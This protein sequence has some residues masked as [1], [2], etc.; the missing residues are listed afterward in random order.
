MSKSSLVI[1]IVALALAVLRIMGHGRDPGLADQA[2]KDVAHLFV[3]GMFA[4][5]A[6]AM[7]MA[8]KGAD[9]W[10]YFGVGVVLS[11]I[12]LAC[13]FALKGTP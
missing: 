5:W 3:G 12:E 4:I 7:R 6:Y 8:P 9:R 11:L 1:I 2:F 13:F 10:F